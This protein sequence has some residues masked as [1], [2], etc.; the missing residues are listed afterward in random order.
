MAA[1]VDETES[2]LGSFMGRG[3]VSVKAEFTVVVVHLLCCLAI[4][5]GGLISKAYGN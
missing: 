3:D 4:G 2:L 1:A 5:G